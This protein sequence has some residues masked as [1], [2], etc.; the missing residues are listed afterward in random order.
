MNRL[1]RL[2][3][4]LLNLQTRRVVRAQDWA[5]RFGVSLRT[6][7]RD[8]R[9]LEAAGVP[10]GAEAGVGYFLNDYHL[11]PVV[12][13]QAEVSALL[14]AA[15]WAETGTDASLREPFRTAFDKIRSV[16]KRGEQDHLT[17]LEPR[18]M[19]STPPRPE[20]VSDDLLH[21]IQAALVQQRI[22]AI[23]YRSL[24]SDGPTRREVEPIGLLHYGLGWHLIAYCRMRQAYRDFRTDRIAELHETPQVFTRRD[25]L[26]LA[27]YLDAMR[28]AENLEEIVVWFDSS[29]VRFAQEQ[30]CAFGFV[31]EERLGDRVRM[32]FL[33]Q[34]TE[35][36]GRWLLIFGNGVTIEGPESFREQV[37]GYAHEV[38]DHYR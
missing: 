6:V 1:D 38:C 2:T 17:D 8:I 21:R 5:E 14:V 10:I 11:P 28:R 12:F 33:T 13:T 37:R 22:L 7:Y 35:G 4:L 29:L 16:L 3:A 23:E 26:T 31:E 15:K 25:R 32:R 30:R 36:L 34:F 18:V 20:P 19:V 9:S 24:S 27:A